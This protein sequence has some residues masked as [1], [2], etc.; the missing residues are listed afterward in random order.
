[1]I[2][3][4][5]DWDAREGWGPSGSP[6]TKECRLWVS[7]DV[8]LRKRQ[9]L[10]RLD[11]ILALG[12]SLWV[13][14]RTIRS[15][16]EEISKYYAATG[17]RPT[18]VTSQLWANRNNWLLKRHSSSLRQL[19]NEM[20]LPGGLVLGRTMVAL[21]K[22]VRRFFDQHKRRPV[23]NSPLWR[24]HDLWLRAR[25]SSLSQVC[26][27]MALPE[28]LN[29]TRTMARVKREILAYY[30]KYGVRPQTKVSAEW[31][32]TSAW[33]KHNHRSSLHQ[34]CNEIHLPGGPIME[35]SF[36]SVKEQILAHFK[37]YR[38]RPT[39]HLSKTWENISA[40]LRRQGSTLKMMCDELCLPGLEEAAK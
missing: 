32:K 19:C 10:G 1:M 6:L 28:V 3:W 7:L 29:R 27:S 31:L 4:P 33:L 17:K 37:R 8:A 38:K 36:A 40:W 16:R 9:G 23:T 13:E 2:Q 26:D 21:K 11:R 39:V 22:A 34:L 30:K 24:S 5:K 14:V 35:R 15:L 18:K 20:S 25:G 12:G